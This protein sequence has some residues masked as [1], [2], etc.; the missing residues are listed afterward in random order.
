VVLVLDF[1]FV[2]TASKPEIAI[3]IGHFMVASLDLDSYTATTSSTKKASL[4]IDACLSEEQV[5]SILR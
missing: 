5:A 1:T 2:F 4:R 3:D